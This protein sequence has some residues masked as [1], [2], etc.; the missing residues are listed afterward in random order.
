MLFHGN[1]VM[2]CVSIAWLG[3]SWYRWCLI[4]ENGKMLYKQRHR[5]VLLKKY[6]RKFTCGVK[7]SEF[8]AIP[9]VFS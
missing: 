1:P 4:N 6:D 2:K 9:M 8:T 7:V 5:G 3:P